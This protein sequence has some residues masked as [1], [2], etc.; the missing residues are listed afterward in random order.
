[1]FL[2]NLQDRYSED[3]QAIRQVKDLD[4][5]ILKNEVEHE[6]VSIHLLK[7]QLHLIPAR[8]EGVKTQAAKYEINIW[9]LE[10]SGFESIVADANAWKKF[11]NEQA[12][13]SLWNVLGILINNVIYYINFC[14]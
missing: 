12:G 4:E 10:P 3:E 7:D 9:F 11:T 6:A 5:W 2:K 13:P 8:I 14:A 1:M